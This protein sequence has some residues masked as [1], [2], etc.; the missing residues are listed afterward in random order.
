[1]KWC[2]Q[3]LKHIFEQRYDRTIFA[4]AE[5]PENVSENVSFWLGMRCVEH[6]ELDNLR[7][8]GFPDNMPVTINT[9]VPISFCPWCGKKLA[10]FYRKNYCQLTDPEISDEFKLEKTD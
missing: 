8:A 5:A 10:K 4:F 6:K 9:R 2:C 7:R 3:G 1:M